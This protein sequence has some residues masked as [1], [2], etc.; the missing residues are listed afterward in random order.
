L[1][2]RRIV[3]DVVPVKDTEAGLQLLAGRGADAFF[4]DRALLLDAVNHSPAPGDVV[5][6]D[7]LFRRDFVALAM[8]RNDDAFRLL[9]D[10]TLS[11]M[12][13]TQ[14]MAALY[15]KHFGAPNGAALD[16][17]DLVALPD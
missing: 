6:L 5:V 14:D 3:A 1:K 15:T 12:Y 7:R 9:V 2:E 8:R 13:R 11:R 16:F 17:F 10:R 4:S